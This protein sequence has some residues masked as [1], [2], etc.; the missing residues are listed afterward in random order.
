MKFIK[1][2]LLVFVASVI[3]LLYFY[4]AKNEKKTTKIDRITEAIRSGIEN[5]EYEREE[6]EDMK[7][8]N[9]D[10]F[11]EYLSL[12]KSGEAGK[13][14]SGNYK[15]R[16]L[17]KAKRRLALL[18]STTVKLD[19][20]ERGPGN[21]GGRTRSLVIDPKDASGNTWFTGSV[22]GG[23]WRTTDAGNTWACISPEIV[24]LATGTIAISLDDPNVIYAGTG[25][26]FYNVDAV[27]GAGIFKS[28]DNG[29]TWEQLASTK[30]DRD[31]YY[32]N[33]IITDPDDANTIVAATNK[34]A[35]KSVDGG[36]S[37]EKT[38]SGRVQQVIFQKDNFKNQYLTINNN[39]IFKSVDGGDTWFQ[40][41]SVKQGRIELAISE[42]DPKIVYALTS[43]SNMIMSVD[44]GYNWAFNK[45]YPET[46]FLGGQGWYNNTLA[47]S[48]DDPKVVFVGG[49]DVHKIVVGADDDKIEEV[50]AFNVAS[51]TS[52]WLAYKNFGG[53][54]L[55][56]GF[57]VNSGNSVFWDIRVSFL[58]NSTQKA[59]RFILDNGAYVYKDMVDVPFSVVRSSGTTK[60]NVSFVD[61]N[62]N[63]K[64]DLT[65]TGEE[66]IYIHYTDYTGGE[67]TEIAKDNGLNVKNM[68]VVLPVMQAGKDWD[69][70][71]GAVDLT[72]DEYQLKGK[73]M[74][75]VKK[76]QWNI[77]VTDQKYA[78]ADHHCLVID[79]NNGSPYRII[80]CSDGGIALSDD[81]G[82]KW[83]SP[84]K[85]YVTSQFY[86]VCKHPTEDRY[87]GGIQDNGTCYSEAS[88][89]SVSDWKKA[90]GGDGFGSVW[91]LRKPEQMIASL[92]YNRLYRTDDNWK[93][94]YELTKD[95]DDAGNNSGAPFLTTIGS[96][97]DDPDLIFIAGPS[98]LWRSENFGLEWKNIPIAKESYGYHKGSVYMEISKADPKIVWIGVKMS[99]S[100]RINLSVDKGQSFEPVNN[101]SHNINHISRIVSHPFDPN[102][103]YVLSSAPQG[104]KIIRSTDMGQTWEDITGFGNNPSSSNGFPDVATY[105]M[106][107]M[108]YDTDILWAGTEIGLF[109]SENNGQ[110][111]HYSDNGLPAVCIWD[112]KIVGDQV[113]LGTHGRG[114]WSVTIPEL[115]NVPAKPFIIGAGSTADN[116]L[117]I[118]YDVAADYDS[119]S[120]VYNDTTVE[121][122]AGVARGEQ[123]IVLDIDNPVSTV[124]CQV[125]G[126]KDG[127]SY[128]SNLF[129]VETIRYSMLRVRYFNDFE[130]RHNDFF[131]DKFSITSIYDG[132][133]SINTAHPYPERADLTYVLK[134]PVIVMADN[135]SS[136][137][138]YEDVAFVEAG[139]QGSKFGDENFYDYVIVEGS[140]DGIEWLPL[141]DGY[142]FRYSDK[143]GSDIN[144]KPTSDMFVQHSINFQDTFNAGDTLLIRFR[145]HSD[146]YTVGWG[147]AIDNVNIQKDGSG[148]FNRPAK[149]EG[150]L[151]VGPNPATDYLNIR[152]DGNA[153]GR[154]TVNVY[155]LSGKLLY[156][157]AFDK[158]QQPWQHR[159]PVGRWGKGVKILEVSVGKEHY[160]KR[161]LIK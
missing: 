144:A 26:G 74:T 55:S 35:F 136:V 148:I 96:T 66:Y 81:G 67:V 93:H 71:N 121:V 16:E 64:F 17:T 52:D 112:M 37:W 48:P 34:G 135:K 46:D 36:A 94:L 39:G 157:K 25:E 92:Y 151:S 155:D 44:S 146:P 85:G 9:P 104:P 18:K 40:V 133:F 82:E 115:A 30:D 108:P 24:N 45:A 98:G 41:K 72:V 10:K 84:D 154:L 22:S 103:V 29:A 106:L 159:L 83:I 78:H 158:Y 138:T 80:D 124:N 122:R 114:I 5:E 4:T 28:T 65:E 118:R 23:V 142:D 62:K 137:M 153:K 27:M 89:D 31:F 15:I 143:W 13:T 2:I 141:A 123:D 101:Y 19:W 49:I 59:H 99:T 69:T 129:T 156:E 79:T 43:E 70:G 132:D 56:G 161:V 6:Q 86:S 20:K 42:T 61:D 139:E 134:Y 11:A 1:V 109:I 126:Y 68:Y 149:G 53:G 152:F 125:V 116:R 117:R 14:Y 100:G 105:T 150:K 90:L 120:Y 51:G 73:K 95:L 127:K 75:S 76:T 50:Q 47:V 130:T 113:V 63:G 58:G 111:W 110:T 33:R 147:W 145:L 107:V 54:Y 8:D 97:P 57:K 102:T 119:I 60:L 87:F 32:V 38:I 140:K 131:G 77:N 3:Y 91:H 12:L 88:P 7:P 21:V 128:R 160:S